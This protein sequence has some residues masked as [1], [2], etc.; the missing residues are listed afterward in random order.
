MTHMDLSHAKRIHFVGIKGIAMT[1]LALWAKEQGAVVT[2]SDVEEEFPS[3]PW[4][5]VSGINPFVGFHSETISK[6]RP[7]FVI[8][9]GAHRGRDNEEV[10]EAV[11]LGIPVLPHGKALGVAMAGKRQIS[12]AG[13]HGK[14]TTSAM[15][16][17][18]LMEA[19]ADPSYAIGSGEIR[20]LG[21]PGHAGKGSFFI[22]EAD[23]YVTDPTHD[24]TPRFLWQTPE[25]L[26]VT[27]IDF[28]HPD[29][30]ASL[31][32]VT[33]AFEKF[34]M[35]QPKGGITV[36]NA[37]D[38]PSVILQKDTARVI[39]TYGRSPEA[40]FLI[41]DEM[42]APGASEFA[43]MHKG[44]KVIDVTLAVPGSH[45]VLN[46][47]AALVASFSAGIPWEAGARALASFGGAKRRF[48]NIGQI[49]KNV[50]YDDYAHHPKE[51]AATLAAARSWYPN[52]TI[53]AVFQPHTYSRTKALLTQFGHA[54]GHAN[55]VLCT[56][57]YAS[58]REKD[59]HEITGETLFGEIKKYHSDV[60]Y[61][62]AKS[63]IRKFL[64]KVK[65]ENVI[66]F[67]GAGSIY[68]WENDILASLSGRT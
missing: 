66:V 14:T 11:R 45:N 52:H 36:V 39:R 48:E 4:L 63:D 31:S 2:G 56:D 50:F 61:A 9:T 65:G 64:E 34:Q 62:P 7:D 68:S 67:M 27:N 46:A 16:A 18:I 6:I 15:I 53:I 58:A 5:R 35:N 57:I 43:L 22:A 24:F 20:G 13:S 59:T 1:A 60:V 54:F 38:A 44:K 33:K 19:G 41:G 49:G 51:I 29:V 3:D 10:C 37:D 32:D 23:E 40:E 8:Y 28:D 42:F 12:V 17:A 30:Y 55:T 25:I 47:A 26:V 21:A